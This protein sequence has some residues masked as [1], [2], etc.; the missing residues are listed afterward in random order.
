MLR[1]AQANRVE[2][3]VGALRGRRVVVEEARHEDA[4]EL[5]V[6]HASVE[7]LL[8]ELLLDL[9]DLLHDRARLAVR[10]DGRLLRIEGV[11]DGDTGLAFASSGQF[12]W[13]G[14]TRLQV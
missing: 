3:L 8:D 2:R 14:T 13:R 1:Q 11:E 9:S 5:L 4:Q 10:I 6:A 7:D 12:I